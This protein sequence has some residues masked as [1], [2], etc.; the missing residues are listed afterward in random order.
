MTAHTCINT[1]TTFDGRP[2]PV[3]V[4]CGEQFKARCEAESNVLAAARAW[5]HAGHPEKTRRAVELDGE[6]SK[7][8]ALGGGR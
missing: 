3:C 4:A 7:L 1:A 2:A 5:Y 6:V 8:V